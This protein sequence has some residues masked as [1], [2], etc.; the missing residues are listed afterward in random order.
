MSNKVIVN[1]VDVFKEL[2]KK[3][4]LLE[5]YEKLA[6]HRYIVIHNLLDD[7]IHLKEGPNKSLADDIDYI[8]F[9]LDDYAKDDIKITDEILKLKEIENE[10]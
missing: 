4:R 1:G 10:K 7:I 2:E 9:S 6:T 3:D 8:L 5:L